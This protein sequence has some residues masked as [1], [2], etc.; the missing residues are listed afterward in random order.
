MPALLNRLV[1][2][3]SGATAIEYGLILALI[4]LAILGALTSFGATFEGMWLNM[5]DR[6]SAAVSGTAGI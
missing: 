1:A 6:I 3:Q 5:S 2:D 4:C